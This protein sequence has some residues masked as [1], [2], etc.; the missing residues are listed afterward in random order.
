MF[1]YFQILY[2]MYNSVC[3][4]LQLYVCDSFRLKW[5][6]RDRSFP[7]MRYILLQGGGKINHPFFIDVHLGGSPLFFFFAISNNAAIEHSLICLLLCPCETVS[8]ETIPGRG[9]AEVE[10]MYFFNL[11]G[12]CQSASLKF[13]H[14]L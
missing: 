4:F 5:V 3:I 8:P 9:H 6:V 2:A 7:A 10:T 11:T 14:C 12:Q 1:A 13:S